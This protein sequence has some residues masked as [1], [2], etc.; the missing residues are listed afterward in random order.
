[1]EVAPKGIWANVS[2]STPMALCVLPSSVIRCPSI[3]K[4][5]AS[6]RDRSLM[7]ERV[8]LHAFVVSPH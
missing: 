5:R 6:V 2:R 1:V 3:S 4:V 8:M 7:A